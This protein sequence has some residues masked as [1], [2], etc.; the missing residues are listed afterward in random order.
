[1]TAIKFNTKKIFFGVCT[2]SD[3]WSN[4]TNRQVDFSIF[5]LKI[6]KGLYKAKYSF[7]Y[8]KGQILFICIAKGELLYSPGSY[9]HLKLTNFGQIV[10]IGQL[11]FGISLEP[12]IHKIKRN[13][14]WK[15]L[16]YTFKINY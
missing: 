8:T 16:D 12:R 9:K 10:K 6:H 5:F 13:A 7:G 2:P 14:F 1:M 4:A 3:R 15:A 11:N